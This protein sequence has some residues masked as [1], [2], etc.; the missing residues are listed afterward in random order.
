MVNIFK[1]LA[2]YFE[3]TE[4]AILIN[5]KVLSLQLNVLNQEVKNISEQ[6]ELLVMMNV[7]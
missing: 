2:F 7:F 1:N 3:V 5:T 4:Q 6:L